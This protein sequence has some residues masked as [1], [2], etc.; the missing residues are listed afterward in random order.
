MKKRCYILGAGFLAACVSLALAALVIPQPNAHPGVTKANLDRVQQGMTMR[1][2]IGIFG[3]KGK[4]Q[5]GAEPSMW[6]WEA[7]DGSVACVF[8][9]GE[10]VIETDWIDSHT[11]LIDRI[12]GWLHVR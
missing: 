4:S 6:Y 7:N 8:F 5:H 9:G 1:E 10:N 12:G 3:E 2:V 11:I